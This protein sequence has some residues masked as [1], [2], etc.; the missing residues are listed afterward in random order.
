MVEQL[1][2]FED[3]FKEETNN[4]EDESDLVVSN[5]DATNKA[6]VTATDWTIETILNQ[7]NKGNILLNPKFQRRDAWTPKRK[8]QFIESLFLGF[9]IPQIVLA[10]HKQ[11][12]GKYIVIDGKQ[13]LL[14]IRQFSS[15]ESDEIYDRIKLTSLTVKKGLN[16]KSLIDLKKDPEFSDDVNSFENETI[17]TVVIKHWPDEN[18]LYRV[19]LRLNTN[20]VGLSPQELRQALHPGDFINFADDYSQKSIALKEILNIKRPDFRMRDVEIM[21]RY[22]AFKYFLSYYSGS[23]K[24]FLDFTCENL[25]NKWDLESNTIKDDAGVFEDAHKMAKTVFSNPYR[26]WLGNRY[27]AK[28]NRAILDIVIYY[29]SIPEVIKQLP[30][31]ERLVEAA[32]QDLCVSDPKFLSSLERTTKSI[33]ATHYRFSTWATVLNAVLGTDLPILEIQ[34]HRLI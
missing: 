34:N 19:F 28:F 9:P 1:Q 3:D 32:F 27:E 14:S 5:T 12:K 24:D 2:F 7:I 11:Q 29:F 21:I 6:I 4:I 18:F 25:N 10:S 15:S 13:R 26:K 23:L 8:S 17:R 22:Y 20:S 31:K 16:N 30:K 33:E